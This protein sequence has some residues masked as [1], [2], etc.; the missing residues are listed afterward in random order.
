MERCRTFSHDARVRVHDEIGRLYFCS[1]YLTLCC[2][3]SSNDKR[4]D[5]CSYSTLMIDQNY[6]QANLLMLIVIGQSMEKVL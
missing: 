6:L 5:G 1:C 4:G 2:N 3:K